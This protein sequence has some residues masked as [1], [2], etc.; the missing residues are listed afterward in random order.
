MLSISLLSMPALFLTVSVGPSNSWG[1][2]LCIKGLTVQFGFLFFL[3]LDGLCN[4]CLTKRDFTRTYSCWHCEI[5][6]TWILQ[7]HVN[8][9]FISTFWYWISN[10]ILIISL[11]PLFCIDV[12]TMF[13]KWS[14][15]FWLQC[16]I[17]CYQT[18]YCT[19]KHIL[20]LALQ[21]FFYIIDPKS[22]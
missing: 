15:S 3:I 6:F 13:F 8:I 7:V 14:L 2:Y 18:A 17:G 20:L 22:Q 12:A 10:L 19:H 16:D 21:H 9:H 5:I 11:Q 1:N 4:N